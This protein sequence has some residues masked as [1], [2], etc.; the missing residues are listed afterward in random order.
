MK[1]VPLFNEFLK[2]TVNLNQTR[3]DKLENHVE[4]IIDFLSKSDLLKDIFLR[5]SQQGSWAHKTI[6]K[7]SQKKKEFDADLLIF[8][9]TVPGW[10]PKDYVNKIYWLF[11]GSDRYKDK[12]HRG[13]RCVVIDYIGEFHLDIIP[14]TVTENGCCTV[15]FNRN[16]NTHELTD[17]DG[18]AEWFAAKN[19]TVGGDH[20]I[21]TVR[22]IKYLRDHKG[23]FSAKSILLT[24]LLGIQ[25]GDSEQWADFEDIPTALVTLSNRLNDW[26]QERSEM[27]IVYNPVLKFENFNRHWDQTK[28]ANFRTQFELYTEKMNDAY[29]ET[30]RDESIGKWRE[31]FGDE[32]GKSEESRKLASINLVIP[33]KP[34]APHAHT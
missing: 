16:I 24:T 18:F 10:E 6:I 22:L 3:I 8:L 19:N 30:D 31:I 27:P 14:Y 21:K 4:A 34:A 20:L 15:I 5:T 28:Y 23:T 33:A 32:F 7:P 17:G 2:D 25:V 26:L 1:H 13:T 12:V 11:K 29:E 9:E